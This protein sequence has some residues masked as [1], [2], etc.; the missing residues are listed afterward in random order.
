MHKKEHFKQMEEKKEK[1]KDKDKIKEKDKKI[2]LHAWELHA[3]QTGSVGD[4]WMV[5]R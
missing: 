1:N 3:I 5:K 4:Q 2:V